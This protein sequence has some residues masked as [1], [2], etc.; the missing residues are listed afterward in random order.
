MCIVLLA[1]EVAYE[2]AMQSLLK[3]WSF[4]CFNGFLGFYLS[5]NCRSFCTQI[6][7]IATRQIFDTFNSKKN[8]NAIY[9][10][11]CKVKLFITL[12]WTMQ[13]GPEFQ[14]CLQWMQNMLSRM[15]CHLCWYG[16]ILILLEILFLCY[17]FLRSKPNSSMY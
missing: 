1:A 17:F 6:F 9:V 2:M 12:N 10:K 8:L 7:C 13:H 15:N 11:E 16:S 14:I 4:I 3:D 5:S